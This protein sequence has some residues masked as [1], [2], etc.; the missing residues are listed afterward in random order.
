MINDIFNPRPLEIE[1]FK[2]NLKSH[3][4][5]CGKNDNSELAYSGINFFNHP[6]GV[7][8]KDLNIIQISSGGNH[9]AFVTDY[10]YLY[11]FGSTLHQK[12]G[13]G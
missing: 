11:V 8:L 1:E 4:F 7:K 2:G 10:G 12:L 5:A 13:I 9:T 3:L 6:Y